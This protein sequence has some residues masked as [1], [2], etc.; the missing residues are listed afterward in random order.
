MKLLHFVP[1]LLIPIIAIFEYSLLLELSEII[2]KIAIYDAIVIC[3][4][5]LLS[6]LTGMVMAYGFVL[7]IKLALLGVLVFYHKNE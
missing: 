2:G 7:L 1:C 6:W 4:V 3:S 5:I